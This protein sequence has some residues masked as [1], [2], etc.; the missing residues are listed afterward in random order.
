MSQASLPNGN[1]IE[2]RRFEGK[3][4]NTDGVVTEFFASIGPPSVSE[5]GEEAWC[6]LHCPALL[7]RD[8]N[9]H[10]ITPVQPFDLAEDLIYLMSA[11]RLVNLFEVALPLSPHPP[12]WALHV[13]ERIAAIDGPQEIG[14]RLHGGLSV[15]AETRFMEATISSPIASKVYRLGI[16][17]V[18]CPELFSVARTF[19]SPESDYGLRSAIDAL[20]HLAELRGGYFGPPS[21][22]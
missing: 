5:N 13:A 1:P 9:I 6:R 16:R 15:N 7:E 17:V 20:S 4:R 22:V 18:K 2:A 10:G 12:V 14:V 3:L 11:G 8:Q 21:F 19:T